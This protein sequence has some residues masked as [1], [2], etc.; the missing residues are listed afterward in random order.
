MLWRRMYSVLLWVVSGTC[1]RCAKN[2]PMGG[3]FVA[4]GTGRLPEPEFTLGR[5][6]PAPLYC[7]YAEAVETQRDEAEAATE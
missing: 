6:L 3:R 2:R 1:R 4:L 5:I 7:R